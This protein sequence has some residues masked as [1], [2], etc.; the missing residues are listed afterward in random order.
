MGKCVPTL[1]P[2]GMILQ[3]YFGVKQHVRLRLTS[4][5]STTGTDP[6]YI[7]YYYDKLTKLSVNHSN[8]CIVLNQGLTSA[9]DKTG[10]LGVC[11]KNDFELL[12]SIDSKQMVKN[13]CALQKYHKMDC[14]LMFTCNQK[15]HFGTAPLS[16]WIDSREWGKHI[17]DFENC[18]QPEKE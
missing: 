16:E 15:K 2:E 1:L 11:A 3:T 12:E 18:T 9:E 14:F 7:V 8:T 17:A 6:R 5:S 13:L 4:S 10:G